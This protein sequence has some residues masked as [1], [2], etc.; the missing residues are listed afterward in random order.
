MLLNQ[1][2]VT[3][4]YSLFWH[5]LIRA[6]WPEWR[7]SK[8]RFP[9]SSWKIN[10]HKPERSEKC[11]WAVLLLS[12]CQRLFF[13]MRFPANP[14]QRRHPQQR[15]SVSRGSWESL[16]DIGQPNFLHPFLNS[17]KTFFLSVVLKEID[18]VCVPLL[19]IH[20]SPCKYTGFSPIQSVA[21]SGSGV[22]SYSWFKETQGWALQVVL[23]TC[24]Q[25]LMGFLPR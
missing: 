14:L 12:P 8:H 19:K 20:L 25:W 24:Y 23:H 4:C 9:P 16:E 11:D 13:H 7:I 17:N 3:C 6:T 10:F 1:S 18:T 22:I 15:L 21:K 2:K 5:I